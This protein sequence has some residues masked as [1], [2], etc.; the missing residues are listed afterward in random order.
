[1]EYSGAAIPVNFVPFCIDCII[2]PCSR[3]A[4]YVSFLKKMKKVYCIC[5]HVQTCTG[6]AK[7]GLAFLEYLVCFFFFLK[8]L[9]LSEMQDGTLQ[10]WHVVLDAYSCGLESGVIENFEALPKITE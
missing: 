2:L 7:F 9:V 4:R 3:P 10:G 5:T 1:M 8:Y 6:I